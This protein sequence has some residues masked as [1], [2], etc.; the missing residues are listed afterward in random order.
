MLSDREC[1]KKP[2][3]RCAAT[4]VSVEQATQFVADHANCSDQEATELLESLRRELLD[5]ER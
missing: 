1:K 5:N 4:E 3:S 2:Y